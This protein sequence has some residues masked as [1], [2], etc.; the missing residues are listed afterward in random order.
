[1][2]SRLGLGSMWGGFSGGGA[3]GG[4]WRGG[5]G[6]GSGSGLGGRPR[7]RVYLL[8]LLIGGVRVRMMISLIV[9]S[10]IRI[11]EKFS[12]FRKRRRIKG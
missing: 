11:I 12:R 1:V 6:W 7:R 5:L 3:G 4:G 10:R 9:G 2:R 8:L